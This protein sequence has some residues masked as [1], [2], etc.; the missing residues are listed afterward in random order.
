VFHQLDRPHACR[1][2][3]KNHFF[4]GVSF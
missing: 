1:L 4:P 3:N 2:N